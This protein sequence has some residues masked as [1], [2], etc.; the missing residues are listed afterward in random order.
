MAE[1]TITN[2]KPLDLY[3]YSGERLLAATQDLTETELDTSS[4]PGGWTIR[5]IIH[6]LADDGDVWSL[7]IKKAIA[8][9]GASVRFEGFPGNEAWADGLGF[10]RRA[11]GPALALITAHR[12]YIAHLVSDFPNAWER[13]VQFKD[14]DGEVVATMTVREMVGMLAEHLLEHVECIEKARVGSQ[15][16]SRG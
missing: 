6:H 10:E 2:P 8:T 3:L 15:D 13:S 12:A 9:P 7:C 5:Q 14:G 16:R 11:V 1:R 4:E